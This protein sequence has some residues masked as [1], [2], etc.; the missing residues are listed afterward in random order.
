[1]KIAIRAVPGRVPEVHLDLDDPALHLT[2]SQRE[3]VASRTEVVLTAG[4]GA[5]KTHTL[6]L[7][8]VA[9]LLE[10]A[11]QGVDEVERVLVLTFTERA[12]EE[13]SERCHRR[14]LTL[15]SAARR[16]QPELDDAD[17]GDAPRLGT[18]LVA[19]L[20]RMA[21]QFEHARIG[22]FHGF[23]GS[24][25]REFPALT[26]TP[27]GARI[28]DEPE[29]RR[30]RRQ[31]L[32][33]A[34][35][36]L[37][38]QEPAALAPLLDTFGSRQQLLDAGSIAVER[39]GTLG[40]VLEEH[41]ERRLGVDSALE[42]AVLTPEEA[43][44]WVQKVGLPGLHAI[45]RLV[46]P[47]GGGA[48]VG[49]VLLP[50]LDHLDGPVPGEPL[51]AY[52]RYRAVLGV[53]V[54]DAGTARALTHHTVLGT[55]TAWPDERTYRAAKQ[56]MTV[57]GQRLGDWH[58]RERAARSLPTPADRALYAALEPFARWV[59]AAAAA[60]EAHLDTE[61]QLTFDVMQD[62]AVQAVVNTPSLQAELRTR[63]RYVMVDEFQDTDERQWALVR[64]IGRASADQPEDRLFLVGDV[65]QAIY[66]FRG[67]DVTVFQRAVEQIE[68][69][70][71]RLPENFRSQP[72]LIQWFNTLFPAVLGTEALEPWDAPYEALNPGRTGE[73]GVVSVMRGSAKELGDRWQAEAIAQLLATD[74]LH[75]SRPWQDRAQFPVPPVAILIRSRTR[76]A[77]YETALRERGI[78]FVVAQGIGFWS[79]PEVIDIVNAL[80][81]L[82]HRDPASVAGTLRGPWLTLLDQDL[83]DLHDGRLGGGGVHRFGSAPLEPSAPARLHRAITLFEERR[84]LLRRATPA[85]VVAT[86]AADHAP[87]RAVLDPTGQADA[88][89]CRLVGLAA[90]WNA[91]GIEAVADRMLAEVEASERASEAVIVPTEARVVLCTV[92]A[93]KG[94]EFEGVI[95]PEAH[96]RSRNRPAPLLV[97]R[98]P[99]EARWR[100]A[101]RVLD[102]DAPVQTRVRPGLYTALDHIRQLEEAAEERRLLYVAATRAR[103]RLL[104][105]G[106]ATK[107]PRPDAVPSWMQLLAADLPSGTE[108]LD[109]ARLLQ[110]T[111]ARPRPP[112]AARVDPATVRPAT[113]LQPPPR[114][115][116]FA[117]GL[118]RFA[119]CPARWYRRELLG[120]PERIGTGSEQAERIA[121]ARGQLLH[122]LV[123]EGDL[124]QPIAARWRA[125]ATQAGAP[126]AEHDRG[127]A[128]V[129]AH[130][131]AMHDD[132]HLAAM[133]AAPGHPELP[134]RV[135]HRGVVLQ[136]RIDRLL[137]AEDGWVVVDFKSESMADRT[138]R[139]VA[140]SHALQL[141]A[142]GW[143]AHQVLDE[144][145]LGPVV[146]GEVYLTECGVSERLGPWSAADRQRIPDLLG[147]VA[148]TAR[149]GWRQVERESTL[150][151]QARPCA[152]CGYRGRGCTGQ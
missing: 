69:P 78:P 140:E 108:H 65:K 96:A 111:P 27:P 130:L 71:L 142:Y 93:S 146:G 136:G 84:E 100:I 26:H 12:A 115:E 16:I 83:Q 101:A 120:V 85:E 121:A 139:D 50:A 149:K 44:A 125:L 152:S 6:S 47:S 109:P 11:A 18:R 67:G 19:N 123:E 20:T 144:H 57:L 122:E 79:R 148:D 94:L 52:A 56:A 73:A 59:R 64:S 17:P 43:A 53:L 37:V 116:L 135:E 49:R 126:P 95:V 107:P 55:R 8:Y 46:A 150:P 36:E 24:I 7:R 141:L 14:L 114:L 105:V 70:P 5:G 45:R 102:P 133:L 23:C 112:T 51:E 34:L 22:T 129:Q 117:S 58:R 68:H 137:Q 41:A 15:C 82:V 21:D 110:G 74:W 99:G 113:K 39:R 10:L 2:P 80:S 28:L 32:E 91:E 31:V 3:A 87:G 48:F 119:A 86:L 88:N 62:R 138:A 97:A 72:G 29:A 128:R 61:R 75:P 4:A 89:A 145:D 134:F 35:R 90:E 98:H 132:P 118:D 147:A 66:G 106:E 42:H 151:A 127:L 33:A 124:R 77:H 104:F 13:M 103:E 131:Q 143:A 63:F 38:A 1:M 92:H 40:D 76:Q 81:A 30:L 9:L 60:L 54:T 25:L